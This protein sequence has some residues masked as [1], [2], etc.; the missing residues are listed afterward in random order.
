M[1]GILFW[2]R[3]KNAAAKCFMKT[4]C[5]AAA[6]ALCCVLA[7]NILL[8]IRSSGE[9]IAAVYAADETMDD[10]SVLPDGYREE[11]TEGVKNVLRRARQLYDIEWTPLA[12][13][14][15]YS[16]SQN[17][18]KLFKKGIT[19]RGIPYGQP[20]HDG[21]YVGFSSDAADFIRKVNDPESEMYTEY[22]M[23]TWNYTENGGDIQYCPFYSNDCSAY[24]SYCWQ[25]EKRT[26]TTGFAA[27][28]KRFIVVGKDISLLKPGYAINGSGH[29]VLI[30]DVV[31]NRAGDII[32]V[33]TL[34]QTPPIMVMRTF[35]VGGTAGTLQD[36]QDKITKNYN[37][38][39]YRDIE[40]VTYEPIAG[41]DDVKKEPSAVNRL[42]E[43]VS[44][45]SEDSAAVGELSADFDLKSFNIRGW[46]LH[47]DGIISFEYTVN[48]GEARPLEAFYYSELV[49]EGGEYADFGK[50]CGFNV[51]SGTVIADFGGEA[52][53]K[54]LATTKKGETYEAAAFTVRK[55]GR[56]VKTN[57]CMDSPADMQMKEDGSYFQDIIT[58][59]NKDLMLSFSGWSV[60]SDDLQRFEVC[61]DGGIWY[62]VESG[63]RN[64][65]YT[66]TSGMFGSCR[67]VNSFSA[68]MDLSYLDAREPHTVRLRA[69]LTDNSVYDVAE[70][71]LDT[72]PSLFEAFGAK[73]IKTDENGKK[74]FSPSTFFESEKTSYDIVLL[75]FIGAAAAAVIVC[76]IA[77]CIS[78]Y[79][80]KKNA[81]AVSENAF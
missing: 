4:V 23:N 6:S 19:Y 17:S 5:A 56:K 40:S 8:P 54:V 15:S 28:T 27:D 34:E 72:K 7:V 13:V 45:F 20:V 35:G 38:I 58:D 48:G 2:G 36:L 12:D 33:T 59:K 42:M 66:Y 55:N 80:K 73:W 10:L 49:S 21:S 71:K 25:L 43:P 9:H 76:V 24:V 26:T 30:Y 14:N 52:E 16:T 68:G 11:L 67:N 57:I 65:V 18:V 3:N 75:S 37:I 41:V 63:F 31:Y 77:V 32:Q 64:D 69:V 50:S 47:R 29:I 39:R 53:I 60:C 62:Q 61:I 1:R 51:Y 46:S 74:V 79:K 22:G 78:L 44:S 81:A 70:W